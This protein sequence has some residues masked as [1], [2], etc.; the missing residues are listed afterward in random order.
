MDGR[1]GMN[2]F[3]QSGHGGWVGPAADVGDHIFNS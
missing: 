1:A 3:E 2:I